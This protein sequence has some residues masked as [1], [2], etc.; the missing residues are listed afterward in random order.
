MNEQSTPRET[1][2][3]KKSQIR[4]V[5]LSDT[6]VDMRFQRPVNPNALAAIKE[7]FHP[8]G[9]GV[10]L[11]ATIR[12]NGQVGDK[13]AVLDGQTRT[14][15]INEM[16]QEI[17]D[18]KRPANP[19]IPKTVLAEVFEGLTTQEAAL[20]FG[21]RNKQRPIPPKDRDRIAVTEGDPIMLDVVH[22]SEEAG[23]VVFSD[24]EDAKPVTMQHRDTAKRI[25]RWGKVALRPKLLEE[26]LVIQQQ[27]FSAN[28]GYLD[29]DVLSATA[30]LLL[31]NTNLVEDELIR[32][33]STLGLPGVRGQAEVVAAKNQQRLSK[34]CRVVLV[35]AYN[36]GKRGNEKIR[37]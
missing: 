11:V 22:Q 25:I 9:V 8:Q 2:R 30:E 23:Y 35:D 4:E 28:V 7:E 17:A 26:A 34:S 16:H 21:L 27:A 19:D 6:Y 36:K 12:E 32:V 24:D 33:L 37:V 20:L 29:K 15:S 3:G 5:A 18:G 1:L 13:Y 14:Q 31:H 10:V